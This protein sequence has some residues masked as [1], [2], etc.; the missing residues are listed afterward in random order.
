MSLASAVKALGKYADEGVNLSGDVSRSADEAAI[1]GRFFN[2]VNART[3]GGGALLTGGGLASYDLADDY[4]EG[5]KAANEASRAEY[6]GIASILANPDLTPEQRG[7]LVGTVRGTPEPEEKE[8]ITSKVL[9]DPLPW[10]VG[11]VVLVVVLKAA[12]ETGLEA[13]VTGD[14]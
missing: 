14:D 6:E 10:I 12:T 9:G 5:K 4:L 3:V 8:T 13:L 1:S 11:A 2:G 7:D